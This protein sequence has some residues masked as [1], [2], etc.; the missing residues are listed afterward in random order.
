MSKEKYSLHNLSS[1]LQWLW[2][3][4]VELIICVL[5]TPERC[6][7]ELEAEVRFPQCIGS[8]VTV[9]THQKG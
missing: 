9:S 8:E 5:G 7:S 3:L 2:G 4:T 6:I 1:T